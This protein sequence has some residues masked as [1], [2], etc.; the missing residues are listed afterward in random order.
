MKSSPVVRF[1][2]A[3]QI[4]R[5]FILTTS[6]KSYLDIYGG[7]LLYAAA[8]LG[9]WETGIGLI[10]RVGEDYPQE[11]LDQISKF[12][13]DTRGIQIT[14]KPVDLRQFYAYT[15]DNQRQF[16]NPISHFNRLGLPFPKSLLGYS[17]LPP[18]AANVNLKSPLTLHLTDIPLDYM[19]SVAAHICPIDFYSLTLLLTTFRQNHIHHITLD[20][21]SDYMTPNCWDEIPRLLNGITA[22]LTSEEKIRNLFK[23]RSLDLW[24]MARI[25]SGYSCECIVIKRNCEGQYIYDGSKQNRWSVPAYPARVDDPTGSGDAFCGGFLAGYRNTY[26]PLEA[27]LYGNISASLSVEGSD[28]FFSLHATP[29]LAEAR[30]NTLRGMVRKL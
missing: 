29:G 20:L 1:I 9:M 17:P 11:W 2:L 27:A 24:E 25:L 22:L 3:G 18:P 16:D 19:G 14:H 8:G 28:P 26:D 5:D 4:N 10:G 7:G 23:G 15:H 21:G 30:L 13:F 6:G 12:G